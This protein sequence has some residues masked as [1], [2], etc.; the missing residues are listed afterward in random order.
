[1]SL[2]VV[3]SVAFD[4][5]ET[6][7]G[8]S[9][10]IVGGAGLYIAL[11]A[12]YHTQPVQ[13]VSVVGDDFP[14]EMFDQMRRRGIDLAGVQRKAG[15]KTFY[16]K[17]RYHVDLNTRDSLVT[18]LNVLGE[19]EPH[20][21]DHFRSPDYVMLGNL[22]PQ[23]QLAV[24]EQIPQRPRLVAMD[25]MNFWIDNAPDDLRKAIGKVDVLIVNDEE[26]RMLGRTH[27][28]VKAAQAIQ[29]MGPEHVIIKKGEHGALLF[30]QGEVFVAPGL[31]LEEVFDPTGAGDTFAGGFMGYLARTGDVSFDNL[32]R[33]VIVGSAMASF[34]IEKFGPQRLLELDDDEIRRRQQVFHKLSHFDI[35]LH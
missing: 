8:S 9:G 12:S 1:M 7:F 25:T 4:E 21:P 20:L 34:C 11:S 29:Q 13:L 15:K 33:A 14:E 18:E 24:I 27:S 32:K 28:L 19:F 16:W 5:I 26:A 6:P 3:G 30:S 17:G 10:R 22:S 2:L 31:P 35:I 23:V